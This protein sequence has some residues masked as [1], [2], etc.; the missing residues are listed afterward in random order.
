VIEKKEFDI[1]GQRVCLKALQKSHVDSLAGIALDESLWDQGP[2]RIRNTEDLRSYVDEA[3]DA[4][5]AGTAIP[6]LTTLTDGTPVGSTRFGNIDK[7]NER[8]EIGWTW[9]AGPWQRTFVNTEA[10]YL[11]PLA[12]AHAE[13]LQ[14]FGA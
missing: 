8:V 5:E 9:I 7:R 13:K 3:L 12:L 11:M 4:R 10:K 1:R 6:F 2:N 14:K